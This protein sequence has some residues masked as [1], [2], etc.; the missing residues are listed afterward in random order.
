MRINQFGNDLGIN[1]LIKAIHC[2]SMLL[3]N[4]TNLK[5]LRR[6]RDYDLNFCA[7][8]QY[9]DD[10]GGEDE[11]DGDSSGGGEEDDDRAG[12]ENDSNANSSAYNSNNRASTLPI[13]N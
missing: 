5:I 8:L 9:A 1:S 12:N 10:E 4:T 13:R 7:T 11:G 2:E 3:G 6:L